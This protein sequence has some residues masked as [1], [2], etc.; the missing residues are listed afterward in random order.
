METGKWIVLAFLA[1]VILIGF[2]TR[3]LKTWE[4]IASGAFMLLLDGLVFHGQISN[5]LGQLGSNVKGA[6]GNA[7]FGHVVSGM[8]VVAVPGMSERARHLAAAMW[9][10]RPGL[11]EREAR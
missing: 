8:G 7:A 3:S 4:F 9:A 2:K 1:G 10:R 11:K 6:A 5:W